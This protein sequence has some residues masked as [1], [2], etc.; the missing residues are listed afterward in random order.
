VLLVYIAN[1]LGRRFLEDAR[2]TLGRIEASGP[3]LWRSRV[4][5]ASAIL[6][7]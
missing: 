5:G 1:R 3:G 6:G 2:A 4:L 7:Q